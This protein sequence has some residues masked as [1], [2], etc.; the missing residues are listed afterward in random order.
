MRLIISY[1]SVRNLVISLMLCLVSNTLL[2]YSPYSTKELDELEKEFIQHL[3]QSDNVVRNALATRYMSRLSGQ[4]THHSKH[5]TSHVFLVKSNQINAFAGPGGYIGI[6]S[7][8]ILHTESESELAAVLAHEIAHVKNHHLYQMLEHQKQMRIPMLASVL[9]SIALGAINPT[10]AS[11]ALMASVTGINQDSINFTRAHEKEADRIGI[12]LL[13]EAGFNPEGMIKFFKKMQLNSRLYYRDNIP[14]ILQSHPLD[15]ER[16]A[17]AEQRSAHHQNT[18]K[19]STDYYLFKELVRTLTI[20]DSKHLLDFYQYQCN[21]ETNHQSCQYGLALTLLN[22]HQ[23]QKANKQLSTVENTM[24]NSLFFIIAKSQIDI[25]LGQFDNAIAPLQRLYSKQ[26]DDY[27]IIMALSQALIAANRG[28][29]AVTTLLQGTRQFKNDIAMC[30][31]LAQAQADADRKDYA[32][33]T[34][35]NCDLL[36]G[37]PYQAINRLKQAKLLAKQDRLL[38]QRIDAKLDEIRFLLEE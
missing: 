25:G 14:A 20:S 19:D 37:H 23:Y 33:F 15:A 18:Y 11:G 32:Y 5:F 7:E 10:L 36:S 2:A 30:T 6:H 28:P 21:K 34:Q 38:Q 12:K 35:A 31:A 1:P 16:I 3:N 29:Q 24:S 4:L 13:I 9:A 17:E 27:A 22:L 26:P 8:L